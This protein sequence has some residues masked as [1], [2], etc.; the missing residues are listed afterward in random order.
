MSDGYTDWDMWSAVHNAREELM[1]SMVDLWRIQ[2]SIGYWCSKTFPDQNEQTIEAHFQEE[3][4][5]LH[6]AV[7]GLQIGQERAVGKEIADCII[8]LLALAEHLGIKAS[9]EVRNK[10]TEN[11]RAAFEYDPNRGYHKRVKE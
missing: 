6:H 2:K 9:E 4:N 8:L 1:S 3:A 10:M 5:E 11:Y 7:F